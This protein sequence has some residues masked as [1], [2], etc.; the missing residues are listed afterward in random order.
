MKI[1]KILISVFLLLFASFSIA[2]VKK[3]NSKSTIT[4]RTINKDIP[5]NVLAYGIPAKVIRSLS[6]EEISNL[7]KE[8]KL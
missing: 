7:E 2:Q 3:D 8:T 6:K 5:D 4:T 1:I